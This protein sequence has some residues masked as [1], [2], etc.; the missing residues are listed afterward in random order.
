MNKLM[1]LFFVTLCFSA[2][3]TSMLPAN[4]SQDTYKNLTVM[5]QTGNKKMENAVIQ[6]DNAQLELRNELLQNRAKFADTD[7]KF[8]TLKAQR[9]E[10]K[11]D[12]KKLEKKIK[13][14][15]RRKDAIRKN[16]VSL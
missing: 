2:C 5:S 16:I 9:K 7:A 8:Q 15:D 12:V 3:A 4:A 13:W 11:K 14:I 1:F 10:L 6:L